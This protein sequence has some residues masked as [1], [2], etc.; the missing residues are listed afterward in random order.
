[1]AGYLKLTM[2]QDIMD[3]IMRNNIENSRL[4]RRKTK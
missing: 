4:Q 3:F 1:M 2:Q